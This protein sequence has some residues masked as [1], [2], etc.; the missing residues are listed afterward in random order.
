ML[1]WS[2]TTPP[3]KGQKSATSGDMLR[4]SQSQ[5]AAR[6]GGRPPARHGPAI[7]PT[8]V[9]RLERKRRLPRASCHT[10]RAR[11]R[12]DSPRSAVS[13]S[14]QLR[15][16]PRRSLADR[17]GPP[18]DHLSLA[19]LMVVNCQQVIT[20]HGGGHTTSHPQPRK[21]WIAFGSCCWIVLDIVK[22]RLEHGRWRPRQGAARGQGWRV[23]RTK[24]MHWRFIPKDP[25]KP[26]CIFSGTPSDYRAI[27]NF[28]ADLRRS[29]FQWPWPPPR[30]GTA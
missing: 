9:S 18:H 19:D 15:A 2:C 23:E 27:R 29:G 3:R 10:L 17:R 21:L 30:G 14:T 16:R 12:A 7:S 26:I 4:P 13:S 11:D 28:L 20:R 24:K 22:E 6:H 5:R 25:G 1:T 8:F